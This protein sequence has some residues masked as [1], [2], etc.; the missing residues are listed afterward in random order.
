[1]TEIIQELSERLYDLRELCKKKKYR[2]AKPEQT[3]TI[4]IMSSMCLHGQEGILAL[5]DVLPEFP[6]D[7]GSEAI[8]RN[9]EII[10]DYRQEFLNALESKPYKNEPGR[11]LRLLLGRYFSSYSADLS[12]KI[13][14]SVCS[15]ILRTAKRTIPN[16]KDLHMINSVLLSEGTSVAESLR[17]DQLTQSECIQISICLMSAAFSVDSEGRAMSTPH[18]QLALMKWASGWPNLSWSRELQEL[19]GSRIKEWNKDQLNY[20]ISDIDKLSPAFHNLVRSIIEDALDKNTQ[21]KENVTVSENTLKDQPA[22]V[23]TECIDEE[24]Q[25]DIDMEMGRLFAHIKRM[26]TD[27]D[28]INYDV[29][30]Y[31][32]RIQQKENELNKNRKERDDA[33]NRSLVIESQLKEKL[34][35]ISKIEKSLDDY[36]Q[37]ATNLELKLLNE[38]RNF[39]GRIKSLNEHADMLSSRITNEGEHNVSILKSKMASLLSPFVIGLKEARH[40][41]MTVELGTALKIQLKQVFDV[42]R[43][44]GI[45]LEES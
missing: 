21:S 30:N 22:S 6:S 23:T 16:S 24:S 18:K 7:I 42:I 2:L 32:N 33:Q 25:Y 31:E 29:V 28:R 36:K 44:L 26:Q 15:D 45:I 19:L 40:M 39:E 5:F 38:K 27:L 41:E 35:L 17:A 10:E 34:E 13:I 12:T 11:R 14:L 9:W 37:K 3:E 8:I 4:N 43:S 20:V 1:V